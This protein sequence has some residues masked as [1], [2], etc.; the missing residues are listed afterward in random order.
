MVANV[1]KKKKKKNK[2]PLK[3]VEVEILK[4]KRI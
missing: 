3:Y 1:S 4:P 2:Q